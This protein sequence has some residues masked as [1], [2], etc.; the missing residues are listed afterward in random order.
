MKFFFWKYNFGHTAFLNM[1]TRC[2]GIIRFFKNFRF[3]SRKSQSQQ[4][5]A[6]KFTHFAIQFH[7]KNLTHFTNLNS[8]DI[9]SNILPQHSQK[10]FWLYKYSSKQIPVWCQKRHLHFTI[11]WRPRTAF[12]KHFKSKCLYTSVYFRKKIFVLETKSDFICW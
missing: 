9:E 12:L 11:S 10:P 8:I 6:K 3:S 2:S 4:K 7:S 1:S 5:L